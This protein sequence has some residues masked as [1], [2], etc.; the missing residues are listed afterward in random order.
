M[1]GSVPMGLVARVA[2]MGPMLATSISPLRIVIAGG[3]VGALE[4]LMALHDLGEAGFHLTLVAPGDEFVLRAMSVAVPFSAGSVTRVS[5]AAVCDQFG[6][7]HRRSG[8]VAVDADAHRVRCSDGTQLDYDI[9]VL[10]TGATARS[11]YLNALTFSDE[12]PG[13]LDGLLR[14]IGRGGC[15]SLAI[16]VPPSGTWSLPVYELGLLIRRHAIRAR[17]ELPMHIV[18]P[19]PAPLAVFG[20]PAST[21]V[22]ALLSQADITVHVSSYASV[23]PGGRI[24]MMPG[25]RRLQVGRVV[26]LP[27]IAGRPIPGIPVDDGGFVPTDDHGRVDGSADVYAVGDA[28][29]FP[30]KQGGLAA[31]QADAAARHIAARAGAPVEPLPF[32][33][34][35]RGLLLTGET[36]RFLRTV[37]AGGAGEGCVSEEMLWWPP[38][39]VVGHYLAPWLARHA[40]IAA[41]PEPEEAIAVEA[42]L[43][44]TRHARPLAIEPLGAQTA[45]GPE[46]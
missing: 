38:T 6:V 8:V 28:A 11:A 36:P 45:D 9:L 29:N 26:A 15:A 31:Q 32:R 7:E 12:D 34:V 5:L 30:V 42:E 43:P 17:V 2:T 41:P 44:S 20:P 1:N 3:G 22:G 39:K 40:A 13:L 24:T 19:E 18:T 27:G 14:D 46:H 10:A 25:D 21:A 35:M 16:V 4:T 23:E 33:P 37:A